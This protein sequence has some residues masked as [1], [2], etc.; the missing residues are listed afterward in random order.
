MIFKFAAIL[1]AFI[2]SV[3]G[4]VVAGTAVGSGHSGTPGIVARHTPAPSAVRITEDDPR[5]DCRTMG[6]RICGPVR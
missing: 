1:G 2:F 6:N 4:V 5:W 3:T